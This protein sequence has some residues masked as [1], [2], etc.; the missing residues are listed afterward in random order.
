[1]NKRLA[2]ALEEGWQVRKRRVQERIR[3]RAD[4]LERIPRREIRRSGW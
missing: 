3:R 2:F 4:Q 1:L